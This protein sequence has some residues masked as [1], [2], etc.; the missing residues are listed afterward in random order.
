[1]AEIIPYKKPDKGSSQKKSGQSDVPK[2]SVEGEKRRDKVTSLEEFKK[3]QFDDKVAVWKNR[4]VKGEAGKNFWVE[5][6]EQKFTFQPALRALALPGGALSKESLKEDF[7]VMR[8][9][10]GRFVFFDSQL[11]GVFVGTPINDPTGLGQC[12][13]LVPEEILKY[14]FAKKDKE[15]E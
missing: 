4:L 9:R 11:G 8:F 15:Q 12:Y 2:V 14:L 5:F 6:V 1:M 7:P 13:F 3:Q 10:E